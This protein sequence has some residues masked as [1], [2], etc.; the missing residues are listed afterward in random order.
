MCRC[1]SRPQ[2]KR[3]RARLAF[4]PGP[5]AAAQTL[6][7]TRVGMVGGAVMPAASWRVRWMSLSRCGARALRRCQGRGR[8]RT[9]TRS[10]SMGSMSNSKRSGFGYGPAFQGLR[11]AWQRGDEVFCEVA[12]TAGAQASADAFCVHPA[13]LDSA[14]HA[15][16]ATQVLDGDGDG[17]DVEVRVPFAFSAVRWSGV[18][19]SV[20]RVRCAPGGEDREAD[21]WSLTAT[22]PS[23]LPV[24]EIQTV[25]T[26]AFD[27]ASAQAAAAM[28]A[29]GRQDLLEITYSP[30]D[31]SQPGQPQSEVVVI[32]SEAGGVAVDGARSFVSMEELEAA[33]ASAD[34][35]APEVVLISAEAGSGELP[36]FE[37]VSGVCGDV[38]ELAQVWLG[39]SQGRLVL[40][41][42]GAVCASEG[43]VAD[44]VQAAQVALWR[45]AV[46]EHP[47]RFGLLDLG[48]DDQVSDH[49]VAVLAAGELSELAVRDGVLL[50][51]RLSTL[52]AAMAIPDAEHWELATRGSGDFDSFYLRE[53]EAGET[54]LG[55]RE[56]R[57]AIHAAGLNFRDVMAVLGLYPGEVP[58][59]AEAAGVVL[60]I[61]DEVTGL[62]VGDC[63]MGLV[64]EAFGSTAV[65]DHRALKPMPDGWSFTEAASVPLTYLTAYYGLVDLADVGPGKK[66]L[67]HAGAGGVGMAAVQIARHLGAEVY[68]TASPN[69][70]PA[71]ERLGV[72]RSQIASSRTLE[73]RDDFMKATAGEGVDVILNALAGEF[74]DA[75]LEL[76]RHGGDFL[77]MGKTDIRDAAEV[78]GARKGVRYQAFDLADAGPDRISE[79]LGEIVKLFN[80]GDFSIPPIRASD[81]RDAPSAFRFLSQGLNVG[82]LVFTI[83]RG[84]DGGGCVVLSGASGG[85]GVL[86]ARHLVG[87]G[88]GGWCWC[89]GV[90]VTRRRVGELVA[91]V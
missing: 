45:S 49:A 24:I 53:T 19:S 74:V 20:M 3:A 14:F 27:Q 1:L 39:L 59:G 57:L 51:P 76:L 61:G 66:V 50:A 43:E 83:P 40:V 64:A 65:A 72:P 68:A 41:S 9:Q 89:P 31:D 78:A 38:L 33:V 44:P 77:E 10:R 21:G 12:V 17:V 73:F 79:M 86:V 18:H 52:P 34:D 11:A 47:D 71:L 91:G 75:S 5:P 58:I 13:M 6:T 56:V 80:T 37:L 4:T 55:A 35:E 85:L 88:L 63:V 70:W 69:K 29:A 22:D 7:L 36:R 28:H 81:I 2:T 62:N 26:R 82:K 48:S 25:S 8:H 23:G 87:Q 15:L 90:G 60:E 67:V 32:G 42:R 54:A 46:S 16:I 84:F 30:L